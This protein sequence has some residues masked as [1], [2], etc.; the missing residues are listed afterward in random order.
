MVAPAWAVNISWLSLHPDDNPVTDAANNGYTM[1]SDIGYVN[2][3]RGAGHTVNRFVT[4]S[5]TAAFIDMIDD[6]DLV[7]VS[8][9]VASDAYQDDPERVLWHGVTKPMMMMSGYILRNNRLQFM[10]GDTI[11]D[12]STA[13]PVTLTAAVPSHPIFQGITLDGSNNMT[14]ATYPIS[15]PAATPA[16]MR[17]ISVV[18]NPPAGG[19]TVL[20]TVG[21]PGDP[22]TTANGMLIGHWPAGSILGANTLAG[23]RMAFLS[24]TREPA[25]PNPIALAGIHDLT[26]QGDQLFLNSVCFMV[27][28]CGPPLVPGDTDGNGTVNFADFGPIQTN[29]RKS[30]TSRAQGDL[31]PNGMVD[32]AD[33]REW[34]GAFL[35]M[36][37]SLDGLDMGLITNVPEPS[38]LG[39]LLMTSA[40]SAGVRRRRPVAN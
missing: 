7:I 2:L 32:F 15:T 16:P 30:V 27:G 21:T 28:G 18:T 37:G 1:A 6:A 10:S 38:T 22:V 23:P 3:L 8:R 13:G 31:V 39:L 36:G 40:I 25:S 5:P 20:A 29:F 34:K 9:Q 19:G 4:Q 26:P 14:F 17:G 24:G 33:F 12:T 35:G 11:P